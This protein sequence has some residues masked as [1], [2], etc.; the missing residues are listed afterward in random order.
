MEPRHPEHSR[1]SPSP[2]EK[3][4]V[5][6]S[7]SEQNSGDDGITGEIQPANSPQP[8]N[9]DAFAQLSPTRKNLLYIVL[10][11][12][13]GVDTLGTFAF[14]AT[15]E[16]IAKDIGL[17]QGILI[18]SSV[19]AGLYTA[20]GND[21]ANWRGSQYGFYFL[22]GWLFAAIILVQVFLPKFQSDGQDGVRGES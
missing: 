22:I 12:A 14:L 10:G 19:Q 5:I 9:L 16:L 15:D 2:T 7:G 13:L 21:L 6:R 20:A 11:I 18:G 1:Q 17:D 3:E 8:S 4:T